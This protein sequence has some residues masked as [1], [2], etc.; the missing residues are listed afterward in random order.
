MPLL[1]LLLL[2]LPPGCAAASPCADPAF[3]AA[4]TQLAGQYQAGLAHA[5]A[6]EEQALRAQ[7]GAWLAARRDCSGAADAA[8]CRAALL[9]VNRTALAIAAGRVPVFA[10]AAYRCPDA[11]AG[12]LEASYYRTDPPAVR[13]RYQSEEL[14][15]F[16]ARSASGSRYLGPDVELW[17]HQRV[18]RLT[19]HGTQQECPQ[20]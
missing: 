1:W 8:A 13:L 6:A 10:T 18:A 11:A 7:Q 2:E 19:W 17:E 15:A 12:A 3:S 5:A 4:E 14:F 16:I 20:E 9:A